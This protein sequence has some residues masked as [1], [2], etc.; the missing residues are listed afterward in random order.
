MPG[1]ATR[2][3]D[4]RHHNKGGYRG[5]G[6]PKG[7]TSP[8]GQRGIHQIRAYEDE[9][10]LIKPFMQLTRVDVDQC[11]LAVNMLCASL[12]RDDLKVE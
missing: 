3:D 6:R 10:A 4:G 12:N 5:G 2:P 8:R 7:S 11:K 9:W 1:P